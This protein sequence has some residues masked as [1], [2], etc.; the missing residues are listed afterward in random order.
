MTIAAGF[1]CADGVVLCA[2]TQQTIPDYLKT[3]VSKFLAMTN[4]IGGYRLILT[5]AGGENM[6]EM[7]WQSI[8]DRLLADRSNGDYGFI[9]QSIREVVCETAIQHVIPFPEEERPWFQLLIGVQMKSGGVALLKTENTTVSRVSGYTCVRSVA[10]AHH[11][12]GDFNCRRYGV[13]VVRP[14]A[15]Q[16]LARVKDHDPNCGKKSEM[17][18]LY[19]DWTYHAPTE[20]YLATLDAHVRTIDRC[21][22]VVMRQGM[23]H[24]A[25]KNAVNECLGHLRKHIGLLQ[26]FEMESCD[27]KCRLKPEHLVKEH[28]V[29]VEEGKSVG[30]P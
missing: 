11:A 3:N 4:D 30:Q 29:W 20:K 16:M 14:M 27:D 8:M 13:C 25:P 22:T 12:L 9:E 26:K 6:I 5:G 28:M 10:F 15:I 18:I 24:R 17:A 2:D 21:A 23:M 7:V 1:H 19:D